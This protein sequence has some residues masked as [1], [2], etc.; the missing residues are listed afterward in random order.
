MKE[1]PSLLATGSQRCFK[2]PHAEARRTSCETRRKGR[3]NLGFLYLRASSFSPRL[4]VR[5]ISPSSPPKSST[6]LSSE[7]QSR[8]RR[9]RNLR[10]R[11]STTRPRHQLP[12]QPRHRSACPSCY[13]RAPGQRWHQRPHQQQPSSRHRL[14]PASE[15]GQSTRSRLRRPEYMSV[16]PTR[17]KRRGIP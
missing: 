8:L 9:S 4:R 2:K 10:S 14:C 17:S 3:T 5:P 13:D 6:G 7:P 16:H 11:T 1:S 12:H 15:R